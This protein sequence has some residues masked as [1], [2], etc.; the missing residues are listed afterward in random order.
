MMKQS[1]VGVEWT[2]NVSRGNLSLESRTMEMEL[3]NFP[4]RLKDK[5]G[6]RSKK[7]S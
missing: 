6:V 4:L 3:K 7:G 1:A 5:N 2:R